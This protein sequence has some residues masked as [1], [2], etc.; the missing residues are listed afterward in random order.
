MSGDF[1]WVGIDYLGE[2][3]WPAKLAA[4]G[5]LD[6]CGFPKDNYYF[7]QSLWTREPV[8]HLFPHWNWEGKEGTNITVTC[9]TNC[10]TVELFL[11][12][13][14]LGVKGYALPRP[15]MVGQYGNYPP[16]AKVLQTTADL[17]LSWDVSYAAGTLRAEGVKGGKVIRI[18]EV[19]TT[20]A[21]A[22]ID[23]AVDRQRIDTS[24]RDVAHVTVRLLDAEG[25]VVPT[26]ANDIAFAM[27]GAGRILGLDNGQPDSHESYQGPNRK[28][29]NGLALAIVQ[30]TGT[31]GTMTLTASSEG[32]SSS[33]ISIDAG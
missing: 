15:G 29:F 31:A 23:L 8:L 26:A 32:L 5:P 18:A 17:H 33:Q 22:K 6:T 10:D 24:R 16:R 1:V 25:R 9:Y 12:D 2:S 28:A 30:S 21:P 13:R 20:G 4:T 11:N 14:S 19:R 7:Y 3:R 27:R